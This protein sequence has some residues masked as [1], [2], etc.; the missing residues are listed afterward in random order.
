MNFEIKSR[1]SESVLFSIE[2]DSL[3]LAVEAAVKSGA[4]LSEAN[5]SGANLYGA[6]L[7]GANLSGADLYGANLSGANLSGADLYGADLYGADL[8]G[9]EIK[10]SKFPSIKMLA[11][12]NLGTLSDKLSLELMRRDAAAHPYPERFGEW[13]NGGDCPY[14]NEERFW[15]FDLDIK[16]WKKGKP[17]L[18]DVELIRA[19]CEEKGWG[20][21]SR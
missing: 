4:N 15:L 13:A 2:T 3:K 1:W 5:L 11:S 9:A 7:S 14:Q 21:K 16:L 6:N 20:I 12:I 18:S 19:I 17:K 8:S 10:F